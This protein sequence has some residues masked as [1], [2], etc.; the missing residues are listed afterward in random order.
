MDMTLLK[1]V[2]RSRIISSHKVNKWR[3]CLATVT[4]FKNSACFCTYMY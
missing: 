1:H 2:N 3:L 4:D